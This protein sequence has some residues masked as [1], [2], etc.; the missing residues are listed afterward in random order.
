[1]IVIDQNRVV[2]YMNPAAC[3][4][5]GATRAACEDATLCRSLLQC[6]PPDEPNG[7]CGDC[8]VLKAL[9]RGMAT[10]RFET[11][12]GPTNSRVWVEG[13]CAPVPGHWPSAVLLV[14]PRFHPAGQ[15]TPDVREQLEQLSAPGQAVL[16][17]LVRA[18]RELLVADYSALGRVDLNASEVA[19]LVQD[20]SR[21]GETARLRCRVGQGIRGRVVDTGQTVRIARFPEEAP[22]P[23]DQHPTMRC[24]GLKAAL[25]VPVRIRDE[26][27]G[28]LM[29]A[30]H[31]PTEY[32]P[33]QE[34]VL[35]ILA[36][37]AGEVLTYGD[38]IVSAQGASIRVERQW[39]A[40][41]LHDGLAQ[42][43]AALTQKLKLARW[44]LGRST[45]TA[46][47]A[48]DL[49]EVLELSE[50]AHGE[51]R[52]ALNDLRAPATDGDFLPNLKSYLDRFA[53]PSSLAVDLV[54]VPERRPHIPA[55]IALQVLRVIQEA[56]TNAR[57]HS[58][59]TR[60]AVRWIFSGEA[61]TFTV[62]DNGRG[63][64]SEQVGHG[65]GL[66]IMAERAHRVGGTLTVT[67]G[68][69]SG[70][71]VVLT[72]PHQVGGG[73]AGEADPGIAR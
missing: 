22:D 58:G 18:A 11:A 44:L 16:S 64:A 69:Q 7:F 71:T 61:H 52:L 21:S 25:A 4:L 53:R 56:L 32:R 38:W 55:S 23:P 9:R 50:Q 6:G 28:V 3:N 49:Q 36:G 20:G 59:G 14:R 73:R 31:H 8:W 72:V 19:W 2:R 30:S 12:M 13:S 17:S 43:L 67:S 35:R 1:M 24:E 29:V 10:P 63:F 62:T 34:Q 5:V 51:L 54:E 68:P 57:K 48:A 26:P 40:A 66:T 47:L 46:S 27:V 41:E 37:L 33:E 45:D 42:L 65:Y 15:T 70:C 60:V 39:L